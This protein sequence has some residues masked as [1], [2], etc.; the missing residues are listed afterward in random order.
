MCASPLHADE[1]GTKTLGIGAGYTNVNHSA[2]TDIY[3]RFSFNSHVRIAPNVAYVFK[4]EHS[5]GLAV[6]ID[7]QFPFQVCRGV[8]LYPL[9]GVAFNNWNYEGDHSTSRFG[10]NAGAGFDLKFTSTLRLSIV[11]K[12]SFMKHTDGVYVGAGIG[13]N[14]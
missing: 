5:S 14:F 12:Y 9:A 1:H 7:M 11:A 4:H 10:A 8:Q 6:N 13:Y 2:Y 3:F